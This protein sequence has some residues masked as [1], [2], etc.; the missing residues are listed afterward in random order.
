M[1][2][3]I[4]ASSSGDVVL[5]VPGLLILLGI[6]GVVIPVI[7]GLLVALVGILVWALDV[8]STTGWV[9]F[10]AAV[11]VYAAGLA[12]QYLVPGK[13]LRNQG[14]GTGTLLL[15]VLGAIIGFFVIPVVGLAVGFVLVIFVVELARSQ[16]RAV[17]WQRTK[18]AL[19]AILTSW[20]IELAAGLVMA[21]TWVGGVLLVS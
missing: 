17:A 18:E 11:L 4:Q 19:R 14:V 3:A 16:D 12:L 13:R 6:V 1:I 9:V 20:G 8:G 10:A 2:E 5:W 15:A 21:L 7:P